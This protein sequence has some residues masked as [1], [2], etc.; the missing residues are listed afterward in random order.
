MA[1][2]C[3]NTPGLPGETPG[4]SPHLDPDVMEEI[5]RER[6]RLDVVVTKAEGLVRALQIVLWDFASEPL[7]REVSQKRSALIAVADALEEV[8][9]RAE[10]EA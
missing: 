1:I 6:D 7:E 3:H 10:Q 8:F 4:I 2:D 5:R 9:D